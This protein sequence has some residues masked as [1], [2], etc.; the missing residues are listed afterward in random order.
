MRVEKDSHT[1]LYSGKLENNSFKKNSIHPKVVESEAENRKRWWFG[2]GTD[3]TP[4]FLDEGDVKHFHGL[5]KR[6]CDKHNSK[7]YSKFKAWCDDYF[8]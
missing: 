8:R 1:T 5:L 7:Y 6:T 4:Y 3:L 2:G